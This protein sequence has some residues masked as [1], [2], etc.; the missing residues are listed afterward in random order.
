MAYDEGLSFRVEEILADTSAFIAKKMF[1]GI[2]YLFRGNMTCGVIQNALIVRLS[3]QDYQTALQK[4]NTRKFEM[5]GK[6]M[7]GW[8][9]VDPDGTSDDNDLKNWINSA[10]QFSATLPPK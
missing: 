10:L 4:P 6:E 7:R 2:G 3:Q 8:L 9:L 1:G 5:T